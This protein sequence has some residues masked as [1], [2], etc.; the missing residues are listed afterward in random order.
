MADDYIY[1]CSECN[2]EL[3]IEDVVCPYCG[4]QKIKEDN[5]E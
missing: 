4:G 3:D 2:A 1:T 5:H